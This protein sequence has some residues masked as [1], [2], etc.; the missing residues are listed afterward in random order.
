MYE[1]S[2]H[3]CV[4]VGVC[5][6]IAHHCCDLVSLC[7]SWAVV[8]RASSKD[9][10][11]LE[12]LRRENTY[13]AFVTKGVDPLRAVL[14]DEHKGHLKETDEVDGHAHVS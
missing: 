13:G 1:N 11:V 8:R 4:C 10:E 7:T 5:V 14:Y 2:G 6:S 12:H 3:A 9:E